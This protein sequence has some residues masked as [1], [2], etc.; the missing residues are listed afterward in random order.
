[1]MRS[2]GPGE[3]LSKSFAEKEITIADVF[4]VLFDV[5]FREEFTSATLEDDAFEFHRKVIDELQLYSSHYV[6]KPV[7][8]YGYLISLWS[9]D[10]TPN[11]RCLVNNLGSIQPLYIENNEV[12]GDCLEN[13]KGPDVEYLKSYLAPFCDQRDTNQVPLML[14]SYLDSQNPT[15]ATDVAKLGVL[16]YPEGDQMTQEDVICKLK[17]AADPETNG[18]YDQDADLVDEKELEEFPHPLILQA[19][20]EGRQTWNT[21]K[22]PMYQAFGDRVSSVP[23]MLSFDMAS[24]CLRVK[25]FLMDC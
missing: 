4:I 22:G 23:D 24:V 6:L 10:D 19:M 11:L 20:H 2:R 12:L 21:E 3:H 17:L 18:V 7:D 5:V 1:M 14:M 25:L 16:L 15:H 9:E 8:F 13:A